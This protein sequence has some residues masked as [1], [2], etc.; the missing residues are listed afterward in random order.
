MWH[1]PCNV[2]GGMAINDVCGV[3]ICKRS[4]RSFYHQNDGRLIVLPWN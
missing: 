4:L 2:A 1:S 3:M